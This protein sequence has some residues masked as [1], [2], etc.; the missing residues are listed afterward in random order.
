MSPV[1][2]GIVLA[3]AAFIGLLIAPAAVGAVGTPL[4]DAASNESEVT[5]SSF[6][7]SS[8]ADAENTIESGLFETAYKS[9]DNESRA[10]VVTDRTESLQKKVSTLEAEREELQENEESLSS[11]EYHARMTQLTVQITMLDRTVDRMVPMATEAGVDR[12][13]LDVLRENA[14]SLNGSEVRTVARGLGGF[15][16]QPGNGPPEFVNAT[17]KSAH[18]NGTTGPESDGPANPAVDQNDSAT[19]NVET[20]PGLGTDP[21]DTSDGHGV[22]QTKAETNATGAGT[23][24]TGAD[25]NPTGAEANTDTDDEDTAGHEDAAESADGPSDGSAADQAGGTETAA[26]PDRGPADD[27]PG[28]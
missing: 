25:T 11:A 17:Q 14:S 21:T 18:G 20:L 15:D 13:R 12:E 3:L 28:Q 16:A 5:V 27:V 4:A 9:A 19:D 1:R 23:N 22:A 26:G 8:A 24:P 6:M 10:D 7:Q 2:A